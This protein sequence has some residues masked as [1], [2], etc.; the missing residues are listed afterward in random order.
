[1]DPQKKPRFKEK[2]TKKFR[3]LIINENSFEEYFS[4]RITKLIVSVVVGFLCLLIVVATVLMI[5]YT[6]L[7]EYL[8]GISSSALRKKT[9]LLSNQIDSLQTD[10]EKMQYFISVLQPLLSGE[11]EK[12][13][14]PLPYV[15]PLTIKYSDEKNQIIDTVAME[16]YKNT[17]ASL[18]Q[19][20]QDKNKTIEKLNE[21]IKIARDS[22]TEKAYLDSILLHNLELSKL[23]VDF[24]DKVEREDRFN[25]FNFDTSKTLLTFLSPVKGTIT[26]IFNHKNKHYAVD[27]ASD[28]GTPVKAIAS[29]T[30]IFTQ[31]TADTGYVIMIMHPNEYISVYKH[32]YLLYRLQGDFVKAG[33]VIGALGSVDHFSTGP[34]LHFELW[35]KGYP[36]NPV[37]FIDFEL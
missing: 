33:E 17:I 10:I 1:M 16:G 37:D 8:P 20:L 29:G 28:K 32:N 13:V 2:I 9:V 24:R 27:I 7:K 6:P 14:E 4:L 5:A 30:V 12:L 31:W 19:K 25:L 23:D 26:D 15:K 18:Q 36:V 11:D 22:A 21:Y 34:H 3:L 35:H